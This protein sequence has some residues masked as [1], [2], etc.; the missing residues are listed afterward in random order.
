MPRAPLAF[1]ALLA[2]APALPAWNK[3]DKPPP[4][5]QYQALVD[6]YDAAMKE[7]QKAA[8]EAKTPQDRQ[9]VFQE[10]Y[11][12]PDQFALRFLAFAKKHPKDPA[13]ADA[14]IWI[15]THMGAVRINQKSPQSEARKILLRDHIQSEKMASLCQTLA[16]FEDKDSQQILRDVLE[17]SKDRPARAQASLALAQQ[18]ESRMRLAQQFKEKPES[19]VNY[20]EIMG[21]Q[22]VTAIVKAGPEKLK[23][24]AVAL[25]ERTAKEFA[26]VSDPDGG[27]VGERATDQLDAMLHPIAVGKPAPD[28]VGEDIDRT[29]FKLS[30]YRG[31]VVLLDFWGHW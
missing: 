11:P 23:K 21:R 2:F 28:I 16:H 3:D 8:R 31:K 14:S 22:T 10:K 30:D 9:K 4:A 1:L 7:Y 20:V 6:E 12:R 17:K 29:K 27:T 15:I 18:A 26:D 13:A 19:A 5:Q 25:F 24:E